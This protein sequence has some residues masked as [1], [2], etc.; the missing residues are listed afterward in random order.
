MTP[1]VVSIKNVKNT[2]ISIL[3]FVLHFIEKYVVSDPSD[4]VG[5][6][7]ILPINNE[8]KICVANKQII[9]FT[10]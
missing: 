4:S 8:K 7:D 1:A 5:S 3:C 9:F 6:F 10:I 2:E